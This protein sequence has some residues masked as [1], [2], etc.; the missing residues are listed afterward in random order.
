MTNY[1][2]LGKTRY[3]GS[4][5]HID[6]EMDDRENARLFGISVV[7]GVAAASLLDIITI[8]LGV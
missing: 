3:D 7:I 1:S 8:V 6:R 4:V 5:H 2:R